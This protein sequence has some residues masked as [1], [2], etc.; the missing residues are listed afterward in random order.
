MTPLLKKPV[1]DDKFSGLFQAS[2]F[3]ANS[4]KD[5]GKPFTCTHSHGL[6]EKFQSAYESHQSTE[7]TLPF[8][9]NDISTELANDNG[10]L[11]S[12]IDL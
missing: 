1:A 3:L 9:Q 12:M 6:G 11:L 5:Y 2:D 4:G 10:V 7:S 8:V